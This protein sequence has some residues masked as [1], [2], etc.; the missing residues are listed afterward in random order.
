M[1]A[2]AEPIP[3]EPLEEL[4]H[5]ITQPGA[6]V[7]VV[8]FSDFGCT[9]CGQ[10]HRETLPALR[11]DYVATGRVRW[12]MVPFVLGIFP[13]GTEAMRAAGCVA[14]QG[15][16]AFWAMHDTLFARQDDWKETTHVGQLFRSFAVVAG[17]DGDTFAACY[18]GALPEAEFRRVLDAALAGR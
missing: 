10:F 1:A 18:E 8:E 9:Y 2:E 14:E 11:R 13:N 15:E 16:E 3:D 6:L 4:I 7:T 12:R 17:A 5:E